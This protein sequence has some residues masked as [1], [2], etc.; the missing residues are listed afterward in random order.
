MSEMSIRESLQRAVAAGE[1]AGAVL[2]ELWISADAAR[3]LSVEL[4]AMQMHPFITPNEIYQGMVDGDVKFM[5]RKVVV[6][7]S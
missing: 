6:A 2:T 7:A 4:A 5:D 1:A 3:Q